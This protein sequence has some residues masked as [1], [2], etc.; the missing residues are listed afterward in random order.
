MVEPL[1][2]AGRYN[3]DCQSKRGM[4][5][6]IVFSSP[7]QQL[8]N[9]VFLWLKTGLHSE[10]FSVFSLDPGLVSEDTVKPKDETPSAI[11]QHS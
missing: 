3:E 4:K 1:H 10:H 11:T 7:R 6:H 8:N 2:G 9:G 5:A